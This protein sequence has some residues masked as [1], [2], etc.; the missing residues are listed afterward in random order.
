MLHRC[1]ALTAAASTLALAAAPAVA[2][3]G[4][5]TVK[6][7]GFTTRL[8]SG[9][10][11]HTRMVSGVKQYLWGSHGTKVSTLGIPTKGGIGVNAFVQSRASVER[12]QR[13]RLSS[14]PVAVLVK[15]VGV[16]KGAT[17]VRAI[18]QAHPTTLGGAKAGAATV[19]Y[20]Y[21]KRSIVQSDAV[22]L[23]AGKVYFIELDVDKANATKGNAALR[24]I[25]AAWKFS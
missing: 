11:A 7:D 13:T 21:K 5:P 2:A 17:H 8:P 6:G 4:G 20:T 9:W 15:I 25:A 12:Q 10:S 14:D 16:P 23:R 3:G 1:V 22:A 19:S 24:S 18:E